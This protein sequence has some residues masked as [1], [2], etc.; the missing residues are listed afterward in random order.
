[1][2]QPVSKAYII[3]RDGF[4]A[5]LLFAGQLALSSV[6]NVEIVTPLIYAYAF[7]LGKHAVLIVQ[8]YI[9]LAG[10]LWGP[11]LWLVGYEIV[12]PL[13]VVLTCIFKKPLKYTKIRPIFLGLFGALFGT[14]C[15]IPY[16]FLD[17][18]TGLTYLLQGL[19]YDAVHAISNV[20]MGTFFA[21]IFIDLLERMKSWEHWLVVKQSHVDVKRN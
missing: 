21:P 3:A 10:L 14:L 17:F 15:S 7:V 13:L 18:H 19:P 11:G 8:A 12:W 5:A 16:F 9:L 6:P 20:I 1:M 4:L 2:V